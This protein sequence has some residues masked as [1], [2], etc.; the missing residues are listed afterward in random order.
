VILRIIIN[1]AVLSFLVLF[2]QVFA[3]GGALLPSSQQK[4]HHFFITLGTGYSKSK[5]TDL[6]VDTSFWDPAIQGY[7]D[8]MG[9]S[10]L[11][12]VGAGV[13]VNNF[14]TIALD[15]TRRPDYQYSKFQ[16]PSGPQPVGFIGTKTRKFDF[17]NTS[18]ML[19]ALVYGAGFPHHRLDWS[20]QNVL[21]QPFVG[22]GIGVAYNTVSDFHS[23]SDSTVQGA[24]Q[25]FSV[26]NSHTISQ[27][28][29]QLLAGLNMTLHKRFLVDMGYR[30]FDGG[31]FESNNYV[32]Q[33]QGLNSGLVVPPWKGK[34][35]TNEAFVNF[36]YLI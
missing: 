30:Y 10:E 5:T 20:T 29:W 23:V 36:S 14:L 24:K 35:R 26:A 11:Y 16:T 19:N 8:D 6:K 25:V 15:A 7:N 27:F 4:T 3:N 12:T 9:S 17:D 31:N 32:Y 33:V 28:A 18:I 2:G 1:F 13:Q 21:I 34:F 22:V